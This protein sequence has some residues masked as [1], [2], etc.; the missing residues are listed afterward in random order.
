[1][2]T[3]LELL[4]GCQRHRDWLVSTIEDLVRLESPSDDKAALD[5]CAS[6]IE[7]RL[8]SLGW[9]TTRL[10]QAH[11]GDHL[12]A[13]I[14][15]GDTQILLLGHYDTVWPVGQLERM[16]LRRE[17]GRLHGPGVFD[18][19]AGLATAWLA[20]R[21]LV[22][23]D[24]AVV[25]RVVMLITSD[26]EVGS[27]TSRAAIEAEAAKSRAV[28]V[29]E[30]SLP[31]GAV[32]TSRKGVGEY[33]IEAHGVAAH[34]G[35][36]PHKGASAILELAR[37]VLAVTDLQNA[38]RGLTINVGRIEGGTRSN[39]VAA[40]AVAE[41]DVRV[42]TAADAERV[43]NTMASLEARTPGVTLRVTGGIN[44]PPLERTAGV[45]ELFHQAQDLAAS[46]GVRL[47][48]G[49]TGGASDGNFT[50]AMG[51]PTLDGLGPEGAGAH[52]LDEHVLLDPLPLRAALVAGVLL[53]LGAL[54]PSRAGSG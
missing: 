17:G 12:R 37:T 15:S 24:A 22:E 9:Q 46:L 40:H 16:P 39:V 31:G 38:A 34:A 30:P 45:L 47:E 50:A 36:E 1:M 7:A 26:E 33:R 29:L 21:A 43:A 10:R 18:M 53:H 23:S 19:K 28:L 14:G 3:P 51:V 2:P 32:K 41:V 4:A 5:R 49:A 20:V 11:A 48:E 44:R 35:I 6:S 54:S 42:E 13:E 8:H 52:A 27:A 25:P